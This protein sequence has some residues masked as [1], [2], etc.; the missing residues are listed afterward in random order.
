MSQIGLLNGL[1]H[2]FPDFCRLLDTP[3]VLTGFNFVFLS[4]LFHYKQFF[5]RCLQGLEA[6]FTMFSCNKTTF[7]FARRPELAAKKDNQL[8]AKKTL[9]I[10]LV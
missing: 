1:I 5:P 8:M 10:Q 9:C 6:H 3:K 2:H 7:L 4:S